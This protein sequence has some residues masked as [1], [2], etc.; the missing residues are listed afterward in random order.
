MQFI[1]KIQLKEHTWIAHKGPK[2]Q[3]IS[4]LKVLLSNV[5]GKRNRIQCNICDRVFNKKTHLKGHSFLDHKLPCNKCNKKFVK[6]VQLMK[7]NLLVHQEKV[8]DRTFARNCFK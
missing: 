6:K 7:H 5:Q 3:K 8:F 2:N 4:C 1:K